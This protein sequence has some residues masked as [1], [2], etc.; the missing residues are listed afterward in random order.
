M[1]LRSIFNRSKT[2]SK[3]VTTGRYEG[4]INFQRK[5][6][7][8][9]NK[10]LIGQPFGGGMVSFGVDNLFPTIIDRMYYTSPLHSSIIDFQ[11]RSAIG[12]GYE[13]LNTEDIR[14]SIEAKKFER[15]FK[16]HKLIK[17]IAY[18]LKMHKRFHLL[19]TTKGKEIT[20]VKRLLPNQV[21]YNK[22]M[23]IFYVS[24]DWEVTSRSVAYE[25]FNDINKDGTRVYSYIDLISSPGQDIYPL[26]KTVS[27]FNWIYLDGESSTLQK[28]NIDHS[29]FG[30]VVIRKPTNFNSREEFN[31]FKSEIT[32]KEGR[33][34]PVILLT[35]D[36]IENVPEVDSF[37]KQENDRAFEHLDKRIDDKICQAHTINPVIMGIQRP[38]A[39]GNG[40]DI[41]EAYP[42]W[43]ENVLIPFRFNIEEVVEELLSLYSTE[44][45][46]KLK[47]YTVTRILNE[48]T[49]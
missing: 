20:K 8:D 6:T 26:D 25:A 19:I 43:E 36:G 5:L 37:P 38:G 45:E 30:G 21:R 16:P 27:A 28:D 4:G 9:L 2:N 22:D 17:G 10:P 31:K 1:K 47:D 34:S 42:I 18:D 14:L 29:I 49:E 7:G 41:K 40:S 12:G 46:F 3:E 39:L 32:T 33:I 24:N 35:G 44:L 15:T 13:I 11:V 23:T 48:L